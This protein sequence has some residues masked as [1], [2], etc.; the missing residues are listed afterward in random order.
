MQA[1]RK[2]ASRTRALIALALLMA[3]LLFVLA[4]IEGTN[5]KMG[6]TPIAPVSANSVEAPPLEPPPSELEDPGHNAQASPPAAVVTTL[7]Q[8]LRGRVVDDAT[9]EPIPWVDVRISGSAGA[10]NVSTD[11]EGAFVTELT[12]TQGQIDAEVTDDGEAVGSSH[13]RWPLANGADGWL[14]RVPIGPTFPIARID[15]S[16]PRPS[17]RWR[18]RLKESQNGFGSAGIITVSADKL[19]PQNDGSARDWSWKSLRYEGGSVFVRWPKPMFPAGPEWFPSMSVRSDA[20]SAKTIVSVYGTVGIQPPLTITTTPFAVLVGSV[21]APTFVAQAGTHVVVRDPVADDKKTFDSVPFFAAVDTKEDGGYAF[22]VPTSLEYSL[23]AWRKGLTIADGQAVVH[24][25]RCFGPDL[26]LLEPTEVISRATTALSFGDTMERG[27]SLLR[28]VPTAVG[29]FTDALLIDV[30]GR[31]VDLSTLAVGPYRVEC[32][33]I[34]GPPCLETIRRSQKLPARELDP[35][36][37][38]AKPASLH[39]IEARGTRERCTIAAGPAGS[40][41]TNSRD[42]ERYSWMLPPDNPAVFTVWCAGCAPTTVTED[43]FEKRGD[44]LVATATLSRGWGALLAFRAGNPDDAK[45]PRAARSPRGNLS[46]VD[47][48]GLSAAPLPGV[49]VMSAGA[50]LG[51]SDRD[52]CVLLGQ[53]LRPER[54]TLVA[55]GWRMTGM[56]RMPGA[57]S[58][59]WV[60]M[61]RDD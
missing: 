19:A 60:W 14:V 12:P 20:V 26:R 59:W 33:G 8:K 6:C 23:V 46:A 54:L 7:G 50:Q 9:G 2:P 58:R 39:R 53:T 22:E 37:S 40:V 44:V 43:R 32:I 41:F 35:P 51:T 15:G 34:D 21:T 49:R 25:G 3:V 29:S 48:L 18:F 28:I 16:S 4:L 27:G 55:P 24:Q 47:T 45:S 1:H 57:G 36:P 5:A 17:A 61:K 38:D 42:M 10:A 30:G 56:S 52:G 13:T 11:A 31:N